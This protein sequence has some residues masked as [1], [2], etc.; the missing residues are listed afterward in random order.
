MPVANIFGA[1]IGKIQE[2]MIALDISQV[3]DAGDTFFSST[4]TAYL[5]FLII[6]II[7]YF[8]VP[9]VANYIVH[10]GG[11]NGLLHKVSNVISSTGQTVMSGGS[12]MASNNY[13]SSLINQSGNNSASNHSMNPGFFGR[14]ESSSSDGSKS[15]GGFMK[16][17]LKG[18]TGKKDD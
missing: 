15:S 13:G 7:G 16:G 2:R 10:A 17:R 9:S 11:G 3:Q 4:D 12:N 14:F 6:G 8:T 5:I 18:N 1:I